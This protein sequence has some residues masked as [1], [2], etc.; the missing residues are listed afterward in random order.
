MGRGRG[1]A[2]GGERKGRSFF[3]PPLKSVVSS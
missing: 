3:V 1:G 2:V